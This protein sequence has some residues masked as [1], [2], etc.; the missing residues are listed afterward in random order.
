MN[1]TTTEKA[2]LANFMCKQLPIFSSFLGDSN[3]H[4]STRFSILTKETSPQSQLHI[5]HPEIS[6]LSLYKALLFVAQLRKQKKRPLSV[7]FFSSNPDFAKLVKSVAIFT[8]QHYINVKWIGGTLTNW[9]QISKSIRA[10]QIF[11]RRW[12]NLLKKKRQLR[13]PRFEKLKKS[14]YGYYRPF[15]GLKPPIQPKK[16]S[17]LKKRPI[18]VFFPIY[19]KYF[20]KNPEFHENDKVYR[21]RFPKQVIEQMLIKRT[22][23]IDIIDAV[24]EKR[25]K[26]VTAN[27]QHQHRPPFGLQLQDASIQK[28]SERLHK[29]IEKPDLLIVVDGNQNKMAVE[30][31]RQANIPVIAFVSSNTNLE[32][33]D[34]PIV[35]NS[36]DLQFIHFSLN[37]FATFL[38]DKK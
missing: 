14:V 28:K 8:K 23:I 35:A 29:V 36:H 26:T 9:Q 33:I 11:S 25:T 7:L 13:F 17:S 18:E 2:N 21:K 34:Y 10:F 20:T 1:K 12:E 37:W 4:L 30:E 27:L 24:K 32:K 31:A 19:E 15:S 22:N 16:I 3:A 6:L 5:I 38:N